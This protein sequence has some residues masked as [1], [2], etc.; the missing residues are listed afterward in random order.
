M[1]SSNARLVPWLVFAGVEAVVIETGCSRGLV[2]STEV[3]VAGA[4]FRLDHDIVDHGVINVESHPASFV[5][6]ATL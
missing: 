3:A 4:A 1:M 5:G 6:G 2:F